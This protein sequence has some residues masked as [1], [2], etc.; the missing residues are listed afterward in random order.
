VGLPCPHSYSCIALKQEECFTKNC[1]PR[2][3]CREDQSVYQEID[4]IQYSTS[5][6]PDTIDSDENCPKISLYFDLSEVDDVSVNSYLGLTDI[7]IFLFII[8]GF[9]YFYVFRDYY[10]L[11]F[12]GVADSLVQ[13]SFGVTLR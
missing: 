6:L 4:N 7:Q 13:Y 2:S 12:L 10:G 9:T 1:H 11:S 5:C 3:L 8:S